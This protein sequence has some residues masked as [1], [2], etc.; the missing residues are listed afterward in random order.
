MGFWAKFWK[1]LLILNTNIDAVAI[2]SILHYKL[3][4]I[5]KLKE[6]LNDHEVIN[7]RLWK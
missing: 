4:E 7:V 2:A 5:P 1:K 3:D 6:T